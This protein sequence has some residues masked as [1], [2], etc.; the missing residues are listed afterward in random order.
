MKTTSQKSI[1]PI[2]WVGSKRRMFNDIEKLIPK[3]ITD[4][5]EPF[6]GGANVFLYLRHN[7][8]R[9][10][11]KHW[12]LSDYDAGLICFWKAIQAKPED[13]IEQHR[14]LRE[15]LENEPEPLAADSP[16]HGVF[17][18]YQLELSEANKLPP[19]HLPEDIVS[20]AVKFLFVNTCCMAGL[21]GG[22]INEANFRRSAWK[23]T[24]PE[25]VLHTSK[26][27]EGVRIDRLGYT[28]L[29]NTP[30]MGDSFLFLDPPY[31]DSSS[32]Y[33]SMKNQKSQTG[34]KDIGLMMCPF[35]EANGK[36]YLHFDEVKRIADTGDKN[37]VTTE[38]KGK[39]VCIHKDDD[40]IVDL[41]KKLYLLGK[42]PNVVEFSTDVFYDL[43]ARYAWHWKFTNDL[44]DIGFDEN[45]TEP[46]TRQFQHQWMLTHSETEMF[47]SRLAWMKF[48]DFDFK[49]GFHKTVIS[50]RSNPSGMPRTDL[51][52]CNYNPEIE[53]FF[54]RRIAERTKLQNVPI[55][56]DDLFE[57]DA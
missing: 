19:P 17:K 18:Q 4:Y 34:Y 5:R 35:R 43:P 23:T 56:W 25:R 10:N 13:V 27:L 15:S 20:F 29:I 49:S 26:L 16:V 54:D 45:S 31:D 3:L 39:L 42:G 21:I 36:T 55:D 14:T 33:I 9:P 44:I 28:D 11:I 50:E 22:Y 48:M 37:K 24:L 40:D 12:W 30:P 52:I 38:L 47:N 46:G 57:A 1:S 51:I 41:K 2:T 32:V 8:L 6:C 7:N 53:N